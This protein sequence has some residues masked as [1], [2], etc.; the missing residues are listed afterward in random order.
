MWSMQLYMH[1]NVPIPFQSIWIDDNNPDLSYIFT[2]VIMVDQVAQIMTQLLT[3]SH[4][5]Q[6]HHYGWQSCRQVCLYCW[7]EFDGSAAHSPMIHLEEKGGAWAPTDAS[8]KRSKT[9]P[10]LQRELCGTLRVSMCKYNINLSH[11]FYPNVSN[12][13]P[14]HKYLSSLGLVPGWTCV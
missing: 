1:I 2:T 9:C 8:K 14:L 11:R 4:C 13:D 3:L 7:E 12:S 6:T 5:S 10:G